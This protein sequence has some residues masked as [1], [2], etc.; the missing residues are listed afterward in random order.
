MSK[1]ILLVGHCGP[2]SSFLRMAVRK[3]APD[4]M[5]NMAD[6]D[7]AL[8]HAVAD[9]VDL[10]LVNRVMDAGF[11]ETDGVAVMRRLAEFNPKLKWLMVSN[12]PEAQAAALEAGARPGFGKR[13]IGSPKATEAIKSALMEEA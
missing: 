10:L 3:A 5:V 6:D 2:D 9:G 4:A 1:K 8:A 12:Y 11:D 7:H 13:D